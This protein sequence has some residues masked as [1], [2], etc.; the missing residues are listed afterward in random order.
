MGKR[1]NDQKQYQG[2]I[3]RIHLRVG[4]CDKARRD[5]TRS[6]FYPLVDFG[7]CVKVVE[8]WI[9]VTRQSEASYNL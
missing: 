5:V 8:S 2:L 9:S 7:R 4:D 1:L 3:L 6:L